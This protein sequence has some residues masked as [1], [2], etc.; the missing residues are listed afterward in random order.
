MKHVLIAATLMLAG[1]ATAT[2]DRDGFGNHVLVDPIERSV[3][4][5]LAVVRADPGTP[6]SAAR[7]DGRPALCTTGAAYLAPGGDARRV[8]FFDDR[9]V[10]RVDEGW[11][12]GTLAA[13]TFSVTPPARYRKVN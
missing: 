13:Y 4:L 12:T 9:G 8:C 5:G 7:V 6:L 1:C 11:I 2:I 10:G 3:N